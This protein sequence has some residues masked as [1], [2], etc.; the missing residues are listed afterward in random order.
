MSR[1]GGDVQ[2]LLVGVG[3]SALEELRR[4]FT[5][6]GHR[7]VLCVRD[8]EP[9]ATAVAVY[10]PDIVVV[11]IPRSF[12]RSLAA[13]RAVTGASSSRSPTVLATVDGLEIREALTLGIEV[14]EL[15]PIPYDAFRLARY[16]TSCA[17]SRRRDS[18][19]AMGPG[20]SW[21]ARDGRGH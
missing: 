16:A 10:A 20:R 2:V 6:A 11:D 4:A 7:Q 3:L 9:L 8:G 15:V 19:Y 13:V 14:T 21:T 18:E 17:R 1:A 12:E 5:G